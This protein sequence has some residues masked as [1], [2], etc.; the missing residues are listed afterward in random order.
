MPLPILNIEI[1]A[2]AAP[3]NGVRASGTF[4]KGNPFPGWAQLNAS[5]DVDVT[6]APD[7]GQSKGGAAVS[8]AFTL[9][10][11]LNLTFP[12]DG[13]VPPSGN[14]DFTN[15]TLSNNNK[16]ITV[17]DANNEARYTQLEYGLKFSDGSTLDPRM[18]N[19]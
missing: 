1:T 18:I 11:N 2:L 12:A 4:A 13:F 19:R 8:V 6:G 16:T 14:T 9:A 7:Q 3:V 10:N 5:G 17:T 15:A